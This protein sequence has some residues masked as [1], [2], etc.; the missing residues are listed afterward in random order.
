[1]TFKSLK[2]VNSVIASHKVNV[3]VEWNRYSKSYLTF[4][5]NLYDLTLDQIKVIKFSA[6]CI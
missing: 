6:G 5:F 1:M 3:T 2:T 4:Q